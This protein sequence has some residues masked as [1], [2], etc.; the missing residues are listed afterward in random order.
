MAGDMPV[1]KDMLN[2]LGE[3]M[4]ESVVKEARID[5]A[6]RG[7][8]Q[9]GKPVGLPNDEDFFKSFSHQIKGKS[10]VAILS[11]WPLVK[12]YSE[13]RPPY[14]MTWITAQKLGGR[15]VPIM[16]RDGTVVFRMAPFRSG[17]YWIHPGFA[18]HTFI[19][20]GIR[21][22]KQAMAE[23]VVEEFMDMLANGDPFR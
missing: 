6:K 7:I 17:E 8:R 5:A 11:T 15:P 21:K 3:A 18:R 2:R 10:T 9:P 23:I 14:E 4:V 22:A 13:G 1:T 12:Q 16:Q 20:R 19:E